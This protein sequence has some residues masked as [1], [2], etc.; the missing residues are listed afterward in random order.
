MDVHEAFAVMRS[1]VTGSRSSWDRSFSLFLLIPLPYSNE[2]PGTSEPRQKVG[3]QLRQHELPVTPNGAAK[4]TPSPALETLRTHTHTCTVKARGVA[5]LQQ[6]VFLLRSHSSLSLL[7]LELVK[8]VSAAPEL[9]AVN[10]GSLVSPY[11]LFLFMPGGSRHTEG[12]YY[13]F[14]WAPAGPIVN[15]GITEGSRSHLAIRCPLNQKTHNPPLTS[16]NGDRAEECVC[17]RE[18]NI[19]QE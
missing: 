18:S 4:A 13:I 11:F 10:V 19:T 2:S 15:R 5:K 7:P 12:S 16:S 3:R 6:T 14:H 17:R 9:L 8:A 1:D